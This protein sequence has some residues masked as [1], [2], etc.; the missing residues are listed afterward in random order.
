[1]FQHGPE[2]DGDA[3]STHADVSLAAELLGYR[4]AVDLRAGLKQQL[5]WI[6]SMSE[7]GRSDRSRSPQ[8]VGG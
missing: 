5:E 7:H 2:G 6:R 8:P 1:V 3:R 4:P